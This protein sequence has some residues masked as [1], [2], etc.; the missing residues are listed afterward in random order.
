[1]KLKAGSK[2]KFLSEKRPYTVQA[3]DERY[4]VCTKPFNPQHTV[5][6]AII[7]FEENVRGPE[8]LI[9]GLGAE[10]RK[11]CE[12]ILDRLN[13]RLDSG[14]R[15]LIGTELERHI[16]INQTEVSHRNRI[17]LDIEKIID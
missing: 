15:E 7:D 3:S 6:Y 4:A 14:S 17:E 10:T 13:G 1:M 5:L 8:N 9:F 11:Q 2:V 12:D 16:C